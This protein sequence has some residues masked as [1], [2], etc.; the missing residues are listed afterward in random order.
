[1]N[2]YKSMD[3]WIRPLYD[4]NACELHHDGGQSQRN[5]STV[6][7]AQTNS[8]GWTGK[9]QKTI[10]RDSREKRTRAEE[11]RERDNIMDTT[12]TGGEQKRQEQNHKTKK[13]ITSYQ[14]PNNA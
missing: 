1:M 8:N 10:Q 12:T 14:R 13:N 11:E 3:S 9:K 2:R 4:R 5:A 7:A 6:P